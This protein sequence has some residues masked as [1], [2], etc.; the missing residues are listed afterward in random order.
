MTMTT[1]TTIMGTR[2]ATTESL[3]PLALL[4]LLQLVSPALPIGAFNF[5]QGMEYAID[6]GWVRDEGSTGDWIQGLMRHGVG[7]LDLPMLARLHDAWSADDPTTARALSARLIA[8]RETLE[9]R[10]EDRHLGRS[11]ARV[12]AGI[13]VDGAESWVRSNE[14]T[15]AAMFS[16]AAVRSD[17]PRGAT[18]TGYLWAWCE[19]QAIAAVKLLPLGQS[20]GQRVLES[21]RLAIPGICEAALRINEE[22]IGSATPGLSVASCQHETQYTRLFRS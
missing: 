14:A 15:F 11:L 22:D 16:L 1:T 5:S 13:G 10:E 6:A 8:C 3:P 9:L 21:L 20:A 18:C 12:L 17:V 19:N 2:T 7:T 4:R